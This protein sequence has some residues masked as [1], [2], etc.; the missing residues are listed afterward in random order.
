MLMGGGYGLR[1]CRFGMW[2]THD[3]SEATK[4]DYECDGNSG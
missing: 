1:D 2:S 4:R 3:G